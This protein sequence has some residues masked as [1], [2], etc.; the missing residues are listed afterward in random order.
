MAKKKKIKET[1]IEDFYDLK[2]DKVDELVAAL[3]GE[4]TSEY[5]EVTMNISEI[6]GDG[7]NSDK[8]FNPYRTDFLSRVPTFIKALFIKWWFGGVVCFFVNMGLG[9]Y[10]TATI[11]LLFLDGI[12]LGIF[13]DVLVNPLFRFLETDKREYNDYMMFPFPLKAYW[14]FFTDVLYY[15]L[16]VFAVNGVYNLINDYMF[17]FSIE[18]MSWSLVVLVIDMALTGIKD[19]IVHLVK[20]HKVKEISDVQ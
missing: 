8:K 12:F 7:K 20:K 1:T 14:T 18:P 19:L 16:V 4:D 13:A 10:V 5:G 11:D 15:I 3:K 17:S 9:I 2:V 6:V